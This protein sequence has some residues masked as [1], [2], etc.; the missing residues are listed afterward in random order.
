MR[1][2]PQYL[3]GG[4]VSINRT[5]LSLIALRVPLTLNAHES[6]NFLANL[7]ASRG[8][9]LCILSEMH[10]DMFKDLPVFDNLPPAMGLAEE[11]RALLS[12]I[13]GLKLTV[14][15]RRAMDGACRIAASPHL[16]SVLVARQTLRRLVDAHT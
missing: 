8:I 5:A 1:H 10:M 6:G 4:A 2:W 14:A 15:E 11:L 16:S 13:A 9:T 12:R 7:R 3:G